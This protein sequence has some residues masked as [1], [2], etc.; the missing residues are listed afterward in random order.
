MKH[1]KGLQG[2]ETEPQEEG[3][4]LGFAHV[5]RKPA[6]RL[7]VGFLHHVGGVNPALESHIHAQ[8][9]H[10]PQARPV[11]R[12]RV[13]PA[14]LGRQARRKRGRVGSLD[15]RHDFVGPFFP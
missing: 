4:G 15:R 3:H 8:G 6:G 5:F 2:Q 12:Q 14:M 10:P 1:L 13:S 7:E 11:L 9:D